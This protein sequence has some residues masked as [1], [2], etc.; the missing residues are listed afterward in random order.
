MVHKFPDDIFGRERCLPQCDLQLATKQ[1]RRPR[2]TFQLH[3]GSQAGVELTVDAFVSPE[4]NTLSAELSR[5]FA[6]S[7]IYCA[8]FAVVA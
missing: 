5:K 8:R 2:Q 4:T 7:I 1:A 6:L 3:E